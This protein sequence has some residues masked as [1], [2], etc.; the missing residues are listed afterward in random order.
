[1]SGKEP[2]YLAQQSTRNLHEHCSTLSFA[3]YGIMRGEESGVVNEPDGW[4]E[5]PRALVAELERVERTRVEST[6]ISMAV[7]PVFYFRFAGSN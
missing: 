4:F 1:M 5:D 2:Q 3:R 7:L 6:R